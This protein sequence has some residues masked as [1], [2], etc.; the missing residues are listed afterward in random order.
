[1]VRLNYFPQLV[2]ASM[3]FAFAGCTP[4]ASPSA[5]PNPP[6]ASP[7]STILSEQI[8][9]TA[10]SIPP[11]YSVPPNLIEPTPI[12]L[13][14]VKGDEGHTNIEYCDKPKPK[15]MFL[16]ISEAQGLSEDE[17]AGKLMSFLLDYYNNPQAPGYCR[18]DG[19]RIEK[20]FYDSRLELPT[21]SPKGDFMR[22]VQFS[23]KLVQIPNVW[24]V[25]SGEIDQQNWFHI[26]EALA[27]FK[28]E[29]DGVY[30]MRFSRP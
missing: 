24:M 30:R 10:T 6:I 20:V 26:S 2:F 23:I 29:T 28:N 25:Y 11:T 3:L 14:F 9:L 17:I 12:Q 22:V 5:Y 1:M 7:I 15:K 16:T 8:Q 13:P 4:N 21:F 27:I 19:Y 18:I